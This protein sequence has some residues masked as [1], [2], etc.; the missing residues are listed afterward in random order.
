MIFGPITG[1]K[2]VFALGIVNATTAFA[3]F[4]TCRCIPTMRM[5]KGLM[6][7][8]WFK[9]IYRYHCYLWWVFWPSVAVHAYFAITSLG[10]PF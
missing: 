5:G 1:Q 9:R 8:G 6:K 3:L 10:I 2:I 4:V 7:Q